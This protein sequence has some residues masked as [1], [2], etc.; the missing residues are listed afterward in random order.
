MDS[1]TNYFAH[2][3]AVIDDDVQIG[4]ETKI[5]HFTH[6]MGHSK[7]GKRCNIG[8]NVVISPKVIIGNG[9]KIQNNVSVYTGVI[10]ED[11]VFLGPSMVFTNVINP[12]SFIVRKEEFMETYVEKGA[13]IGA[14]ATVV[15]GNRIGAYAMIG[16]GAVITK[17]VKPYAL[18]IGNPGKQIGWV[19]KHGHRLDFKSADIAICPESGYSYKLHNE[20][21]SPI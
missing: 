5:W 14:N 18:I 15:C 21:V 20:T 16:A 17:P 11:D 10:C 7:I 8:Q 1:Q 6:I 13:T 12:R 9:V 4:S 2:A 19:S 3:T